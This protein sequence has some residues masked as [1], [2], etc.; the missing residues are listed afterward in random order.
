MS[1]RTHTRECTTAREKKTATKKWDISQQRQRTICMSIWTESLHIQLSDIPVTIRSRIRFYAW[2]FCSVHLSNGIKYI[3]YGCIHR[4]LFCVFV[5]WC[6]NSSRL[7]SKAE[8]KREYIV[9]PFRLRRRRRLLLLLRSYEITTIRKICAWIQREKVS[10]DWVY[11]LYMYNRIY[12]KGIGKQWQENIRNLLVVVL[13]LLAKR[14]T[15]KKGE[16][17]KKS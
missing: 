9:F 2:Y 17:K 4:S 14:I 8:K 16:E 6:E 10:L 3:Q 15:R 12:I 7:N 1:A 13:L 5:S 11:I